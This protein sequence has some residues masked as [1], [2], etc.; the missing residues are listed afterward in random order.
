MRREFWLVLGAGL[1]VS[2]QVWGQTPLNACDL[3]APFGTID[4]NDVN[5]AI[6]MA[7]GTSACTANVM[8]SSVCNVVVT[9]RIV[10]AALGQGCVVGTHSVVLTWN[11]STAGTYPI[12]GYNVFRA[13]SSNP[14]QYVQ[15]NTTPVNALTFTDGAV[16]NSASY[17]YAVTAVDS[18]NN[19]SAYSTPA[20]AVIP[21]T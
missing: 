19:Q 12:N 8:G 10:N 3:A 7:I 4:Q 21:S 15:L 1:L 14:T 18:Q 6:G 5:A 11:A 2:A 13:P 9:Q 17:V 16:S 20:T